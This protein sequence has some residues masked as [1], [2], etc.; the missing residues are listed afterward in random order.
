MDGTRAS[1]LEVREAPSIET[2]DD[3]ALEFVD[4][5]R[6]PSGVESDILERLRMLGYIEDSE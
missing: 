3:L 1:F 6:A 2:Y 5:D 4:P